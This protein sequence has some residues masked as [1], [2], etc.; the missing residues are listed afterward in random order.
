MRKFFSYTLILAL[1]SIGCATLAGDKTKEAYNDQKASMQ[2]VTKGVGYAAQGKFKDAEE[3]FEKAL[4]SYPFRESAKE[5]LRII[6][7]VGDKK[8]DSKTAV[9]LFKGAAYIIIGQTGEAISEYNK[10]I[11]TNPRHAS[12][13]KYRGL[14]YYVKGQY[15]KAIVDYNMAIKINPKYAA[16]YYNRGLAYYVKGQ[17]DNAIVDYN[18]A[19]EINPGLASAYYNR[20]LAY[21]GKG[22]YDQAISDYS[23][24][25]ELNPRYVEAYNN[26]GVAY[27]HKGEYDKA[28]ED[29]HMEQSL[30]IEVHPGFL[31]ALREASGIQ[32]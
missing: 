24:A 19:I 25:I 5:S 1:I 31:K 18:K 13:Y 30:G 29:V 23:K 17:Y 20:G 6:E 4:K 22:Q 10:A 9:L 32:R 26:R 16:A 7:D 14:A 28:W 12:A 27:Y 3:E 15:D 2:N 21:Y 11:E 8:L